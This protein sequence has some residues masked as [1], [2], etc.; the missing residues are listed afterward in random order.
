M[1]DQITGIVYTKNVQRSVISDGPDGPLGDQ[2]IASGLVFASPKDSRPVG[3]F[4][5]TAFTTSVEGDQERRQVFIELSLNNSY[6]RRSW[7]AAGIR[8]SSLKKHSRSDINL[9]GVEAYPAGGGIPSHPIR[10]GLA[11]GTGV[12]IRTDG[13][14]DISYN[15]VTQVFTYDLSLYVN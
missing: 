14:A 10:L 15:Q 1:P 3:V 12:F 6:I 9:M 13:V 7:L 8:G 5:L 4:D 2:V 11:A